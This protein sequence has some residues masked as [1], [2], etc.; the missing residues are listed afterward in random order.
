VERESRSP[1]PLE[2]LE[3]RRL[4]ESEQWNLWSDSLAFARDDLSGR[5]VFQSIEGPYRLELA[6]KGIEWGLGQRMTLE[7]PS[8]SVG[9]GNLEVEFSS[10]IPSTLSVQL[11]SRGLNVPLPSSWWTQ[12]EF[13]SPSGDKLSPFRSQLGGPDFSSDPNRGEFLFTDG[14]PLEVRF[15]ATEEFLPIPSATVQL[16]TGETSTLALELEPVL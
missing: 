9:N 11:S 3:F 13:S 15:P 16:V 4:G 6:A 1:V 10:A 12:I 7:I 2:E 5:A 8:L 14:G